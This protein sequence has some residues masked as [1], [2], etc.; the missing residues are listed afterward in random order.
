MDP[1]HLQEILCVL[2]LLRPNPDVQRVHVQ[3]A[4]IEDCFEGAAGGRRVGSLVEKQSQMLV[5][6]D[7]TVVKF[8]QSPLV[9]VLLV[10]Q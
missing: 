6:E 5:G 7:N 1:A 4:M 9:D 3:G 8:S 10:T 2:L